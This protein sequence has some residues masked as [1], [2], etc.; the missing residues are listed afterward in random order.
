MMLVSTAHSNLVFAMAVDVLG[1]IPVLM[2]KAG[3]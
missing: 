1:M 2:V 3:R